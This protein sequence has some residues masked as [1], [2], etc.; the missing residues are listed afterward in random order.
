[1]IININNKSSQDRVITCIDN[2]TIKSYPV[3]T[4]EQ[5][6]FSSVEPLA[7][8]ECDGSVILLPTIFETANYAIIDDKDIY[9]ERKQADVIYFICLVLMCALTILFLKTTI[10]YLILFLVIQALI[11]TGVYKILKSEQKGE[12]VF[13]ER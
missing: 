3:K 4:N 13:I 2:G 8:I 10:I 11:I 9:R 7:E 1:M 5:V 12:V 6:E